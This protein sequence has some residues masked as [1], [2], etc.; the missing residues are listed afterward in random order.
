M[1]PTPRRAFSSFHGTRALRG[2]PFLAFRAIAVATAA[3]VAT[4]ATF[5]AEA[6]MEPEAAL[7]ARAAALHA[8]IFTLDT[9]LDTPTFSLR[10]PGW[11]I[12]ERHAVGPDYS[13]CDFPRMRD[14]GLDAGVFVVF[15]DQGA[16]T[17]AG[18]AAIRD[19]AL[20]TFLR[21]HA[22]AARHP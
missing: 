11:D 10:R 17:S 21:I 12:A 14:G 8:R 18:Y 2:T 1:L 9:H 13:Q 15:V 5:A 22:M 7:A 20:R 4:T 19:N 6:A 3:F 16:R